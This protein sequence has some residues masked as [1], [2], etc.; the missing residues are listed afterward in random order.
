M[1]NRSSLKGCLNKLSVELT[2][3]NLSLLHVSVAVTLR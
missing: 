2:H 1:K 3:F